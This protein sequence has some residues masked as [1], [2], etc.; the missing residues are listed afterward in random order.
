MEFRS[1]LIHLYQTIYAIYI[2]AIYDHILA[3]CGPLV[4]SQ[5]KVNMECIVC[6]DTYTLCAYYSVTHSK[7]KC[8][9]KNVMLSKKL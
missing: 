8:P 6:V 4:F 2:Y 7:A 5:V 3:W 9:N 1:I